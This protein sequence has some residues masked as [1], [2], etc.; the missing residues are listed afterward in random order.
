MR[1]FKFFF[2]FISVGV[3]FS[4]C[5][6]DEKNLEGIWDL[7]RVVTSN[8]QDPADNSVIDFSTNNGCQSLGLFSICIKATTEFRNGTYTTVFTTTTSVLG[9]TETET[10]T[11]TGTYSVEGNKITVCDGASD[12]R[13]GEFTISGDNLT[14]NANDDELKCKTVQTMKRR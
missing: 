5:S 12:C 11:E 8:C 1:I 3:L 6:K 14:I 9:S 13:V 2:L 10:E 4:A 7:Q